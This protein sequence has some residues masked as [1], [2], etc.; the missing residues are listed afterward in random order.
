MTLFLSLKVFSE[1][2]YRAAPY[3]LN[4]VLNKDALFHCLYACLFANV[5]KNLTFVSY[6]WAK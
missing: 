4:L 2:L 3:R 6:K 1:D 5:R